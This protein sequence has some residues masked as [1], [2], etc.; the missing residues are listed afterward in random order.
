MVLGDPSYLPG[1]AA[2]WLQF[3]VGGQ[4]REETKKAEMVNYCRFWK[5]NRIRS[6]CGSDEN[7]TFPFCLDWGGGGQ[8]APG[9]RK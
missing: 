4:R 9:N 1:Q 7:S 2:T 6:I 8:S 5:K 3:A